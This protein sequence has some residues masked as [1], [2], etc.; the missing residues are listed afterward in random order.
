MD[1]YYFRRNKMGYDNTNKGALFKNDKKNK[2]TDRDY[3][4]QCEIVCPHCGATSE[5]WISAWINEA[6]SGKKYM[7]LRFNEK[8]PSQP[9]YENKSISNDSFDD[10]IPF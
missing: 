7:S 5:H 3:N 2:D 4:G 10:D 9:K 8:E 1:G 6:K